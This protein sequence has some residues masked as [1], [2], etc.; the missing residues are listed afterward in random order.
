LPPSPLPLDPDE[1]ATVASI[2]ELVP[3]DE[4]PELPEVPPDVLPPELPEE[5]PDVPPPELPEPEL[6]AP[7][8]PSWLASAA[9]ATES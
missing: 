4:P 7:A 5:L 6:L 9:V 3:L 2:P 1:S 8:P